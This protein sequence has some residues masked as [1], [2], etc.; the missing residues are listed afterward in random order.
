MDE[1]QQ[2][3]TPITVEANPTTNF[4]VNTMSIFIMF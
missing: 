2:Y 1:T 4:C 3:H